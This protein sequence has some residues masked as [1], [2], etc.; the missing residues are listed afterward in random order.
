MHKAFKQQPCSS[1][2][3]AA[4]IYTNYNSVFPLHL[5]LLFTVHKG[6]PASAIIIT[7]WHSTGLVDCGQS[8]LPAEAAAAELSAIAQTLTLTF[9]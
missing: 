5:L 9:T 4:S 8:Q 1:P 6:F 2:A 3:Q 7:A